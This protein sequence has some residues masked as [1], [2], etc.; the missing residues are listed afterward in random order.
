MPSCFSMLPATKYRT[1]SVPPRTDASKFEIG[2][3]RVTSSSQSVSTPRG[4]ST[5]KTPS[6]S[7]PYQ[8]SSP[9][10]AG[11]PKRL[12]RPSLDLHVLLGVEEVDHPPRALPAV[13]T[14]ER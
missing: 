9:K 3:V 12:I 7:K 1:A 5:S 6:P 13:V 11:S 8:L 4:T 14:A 10:S 2:A